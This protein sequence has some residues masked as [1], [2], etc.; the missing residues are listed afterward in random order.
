[1][2]E[3]VIVDQSRIVVDRETTKQT[4]QRTFVGG[5]LPEGVLCII[6]ALSDDERAALFAEIRTL[7]CLHCGTEDPDCRCWDDS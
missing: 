6:A 5:D 4:M 1:M 2:A 7:F 3:H